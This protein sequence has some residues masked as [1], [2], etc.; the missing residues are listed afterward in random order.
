MSWTNLEDKK[1]KVFITNKVVEVEEMSRLEYVLSRGWEL[2]ENESHLKDE[3]VYKVYYKD[4][5]IS[6]CPKD[7]FLEDAHELEKLNFELALMLLKRGHKLARTGW[8]GKDMFIYYV[9]GG[10]Y[11]AQMDSIKGVYPG[12]LVPYN[13]YF[14]IKNVDGTVSTWVP[15]VNDLLANDWEVIGINEFDRAWIRE[16][17]RECLAR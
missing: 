8:N 12:D 15:S 1:K 13:P 10:K 7:T 3:R 4:G 17:V 6:M 16:K 14:A 11:K 5:Y 2:P 9:E